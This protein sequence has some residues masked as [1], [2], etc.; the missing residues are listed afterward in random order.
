MKISRSSEGVDKGKFKYPSDIAMDSSGN[1]YGD[2]LGNYHI[3]VFS[4]VTK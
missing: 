4:L 1:M 3:Q 2:D